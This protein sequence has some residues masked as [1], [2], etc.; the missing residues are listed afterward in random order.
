[1][2]IT[3][4]LNILILRWNIGQGIQVHQSSNVANLAEIANY[5]CQPCCNAGLF[6]DIWY[7]LSRRVDNIFWQKKIYMSVDCLGILQQP[8]LLHWKV[9]GQ[10]TNLLYGIFVFHLGSHSENESGSYGKKNMSCT[11]IMV[12]HINNTCVL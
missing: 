9:E 6:C 12:T 1:M 8:V 10:S 7:G 11:T 5:H 4:W 2:H 3:C